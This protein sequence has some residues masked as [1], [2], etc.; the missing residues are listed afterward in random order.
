M[1]AEK[2]AEKTIMVIY[3]DEALME[4]AAEISARENKDDDLPWI[5]NELVKR[6]GC[7]DEDAHLAVEAFVAKYYP[8]TLQS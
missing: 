1:T 5:E 6:F 8:Y 3:A 2:Q 7:S 4:S